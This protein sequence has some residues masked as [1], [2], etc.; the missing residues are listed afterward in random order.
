[1]VI[2]ML[3][4]LHGRK[5]SERDSQQS[6]CIDAKG[7]RGLCAHNNSPLVYLAHH[8]KDSKQIKHLYEDRHIWVPIY[9]DHHFWA[10]MRSIQRSESMHSFFNKFITRN[11]S[12]IQLSNKR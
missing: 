4:S 1:M 2:S 3:T 11:S 5:G 12:L 6:M 7:Y 8:E 9:L 10:G